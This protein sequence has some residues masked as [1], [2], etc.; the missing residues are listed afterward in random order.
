MDAV[1]IF[2][3]A[4]DAREGKPL[5][6]SYTVDVDLPEREE[7]MVIERAKKNR[8]A[9][10]GPTPDTTYHFLENA[11]GRLPHRPLLLPCL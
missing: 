6:F 1:K 3:R 8:N 11:F 5:M 2:Q 7:V 9:Q 10:I 4:V